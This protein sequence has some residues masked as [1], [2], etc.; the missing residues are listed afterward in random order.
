MCNIN[1]FSNRYLLVFFHDLK[2]C[3][4]HSIIRE[5]FEINQEI[6]DEEISAI[7]NSKEQLLSF[8]IGDMKFIDAYACLCESLD[9]LVKNL[10]DKDDKFKNFLNMNKTL[11]GTYGPLISKGLLSIRM[12]RRN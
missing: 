8:K 6:G 12:G 4:G 5:E 2:G 1:F 9:Q 10:Y 11:R 7:P 3:D